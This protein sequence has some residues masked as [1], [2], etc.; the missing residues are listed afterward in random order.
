MPS[1]QV[2]SSSHCAVREGPS[3]VYL[4]VTR[5]CKNDKFFFQILHSSLM[6]RFSTALSKDSGTPDA[7][8]VEAMVAEA[9]GSLSEVLA[10]LEEG[11]E[12]LQFKMSNLLFS[13]P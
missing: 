13:Q 9:S 3:S 7:P 5:S 11:Y 6:T 2:T 8:A 4:I 10:S 1:R 12:V